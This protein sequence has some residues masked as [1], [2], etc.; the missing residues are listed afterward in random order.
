MSHRKIFHLLFE[1][2]VENGI[3]TNVT[4]QVEIRNSI[5]YLF[6]NT[7]NT[8]KKVIMVLITAFFLIAML[9]SCN[10]NVCPA[11]VMDGTTEQA[12]NNG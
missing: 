9:A 6:I 2:F 5:V 7:P 1:L 12:E 3:Y 10:K 4:H 11:Y 8:M